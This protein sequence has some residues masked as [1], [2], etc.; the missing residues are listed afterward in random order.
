MIHKL[1]RTAPGCKAALYTDQQYLWEESGLC[2]KLNLL[3]KY[4]SSRLAGYVNATRHC[5]SK[6]FGYFCSN[7]IFRKQLGEIA[8]VRRELKCNIALWIFLWTENVAG[9]DFF[10]PL[11]TKA[12]ENSTNIGVIYYLRCNSSGFSDKVEILI[13]SQRC[14][15]W[16]QETVKRDNIP[17]DVLL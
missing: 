9:W 4:S 6:D 2:L 7:G 12:G 8:G 11:N 13:L 14:E 15:S 17:A 16:M 1:F 3:I 5:K 10:S